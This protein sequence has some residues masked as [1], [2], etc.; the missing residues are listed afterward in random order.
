MTEPQLDRII[1][2]SHRMVFVQRYHQTGQFG[3]F[4][5]RRSTATDPTTRKATWR[6]GRRELGADWLG[7]SRRKWRKLRNRSKDVV[8][9]VLAP[10]STL[11]VGL[12]RRKK[13]ARRRK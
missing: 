8:E 12:G 11:T 13:E 2:E 1:A 9:G 6:K 7:A 10:C 4:D 5:H 3:Q